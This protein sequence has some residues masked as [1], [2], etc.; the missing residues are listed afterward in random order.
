MRFAAVIVAAGSGSRAGEGPAKQWRMFGGR[1]V[2]RWSAEAFASAGAAEIVVV[3]PRTDRDAASQALVGLPSIRLADGG[4]T[5]TQSVAA[6]L[7]CTSADVEV[8][9]IHDAARPFLTAS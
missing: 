4:A 5:R 9:L 8:V 6:G 7:A 2:L 1:P 3:V